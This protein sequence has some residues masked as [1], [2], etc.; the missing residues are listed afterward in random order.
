MSYWWVNHK[1][2]AHVEINEGYIWSPQKNSDNSKNETYLNLT[3]AKPGE[4]IFSYANG[5]IAAVGKIM[6]PA[7]EERK[8]PNFGSAGDRWNKEGWRVEVEWVRVENPIKP[9]DHL[10]EIVPLLPTKNSPLQTN[11]NGNQRCY[12]AEIDAKLGRVLLNLLN[13]PS[14]DIT[15]QLEEIEKNLEEEKEVEDLQDSHLAKTDRDQLIKAR[16]GQG[17]FRSNVEEIETACRVTG[18]TDKR[19][20]IASHIK[21]WRDSNNSE[22]LDGDNGFLLSPHVDKLFDKGWVSFSDQGYLLMSSEH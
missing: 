1:Q 2:T 15:E 17:V 20:L 12:L 7:E 6:S 11:G 9:K 5:K 19:L 13:T 18:L 8:P 10:P 22:R 14:H 3:K 16:L 4:T 21:P